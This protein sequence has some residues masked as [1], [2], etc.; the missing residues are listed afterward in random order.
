[1]GIVPTF[2]SAKN[3]YNDL[4]RLVF[5]TTICSDL[6]GGIGC[7]G[8]VGYGFALR[9]C[10]LV[11]VPKG[12]ARIHTFYPTGH[13]ANEIGTGRT[14]LIHSL[15]DDYSLGR[16]FIAHSNGKKSNHVW[17]GIS[18]WEKNVPSFKLPC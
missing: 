8:R 7:L 1:M 11:L 12:N 10:D 17:P 16:K 2:D 15:N 9:G 14:R 5:D 3:F 4:L 18:R 13:R 6:G